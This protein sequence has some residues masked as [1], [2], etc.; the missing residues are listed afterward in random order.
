MLIWL[1]LF[2]MVAALG[3][4]IYVGLGAPGTKGRQDRVVPA[5]KA[6]RLKKRHIDWHRRLSR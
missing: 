5:G 2:G 3:A 1:I 6:R 4:G